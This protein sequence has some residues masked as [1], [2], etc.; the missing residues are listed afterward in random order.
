MAKAWTDALQKKLIQKLGA[1]KGAL[2]GK[3]YADAFSHSYKEDFSPTDALFDIELIE[4]LSPNNLLEIDIYEQNK[5]NQNRIYLKLLQFGK[6]IPLSDVLPM[7]ENMDLRTFSERPYRITVD[8]DTVIWLS[9]FTLDYVEPLAIKIGKIEKYFRDA[10]IKINNGECENDG[11]NKLILGAELPWR[12]VMILRIYAKYLHQIGFRLGQSYIEK[13]L[14]KYPDITKL[15]VSLFKIKFD[16]EQTSIKA[17][18]ATNA[19]ITESIDSVSSLDED[20]ILRNIWKL[21][22]ATLRTNYFQLTKKGV[23]KE[24]ISLKLASSD[25]PDLPLPHPLYE[26]FVYSPRFEAIHLRSAKVARGGIRWSDRP[27]DFRTEVLGLMK[28]QKVKNAIIVPSGAKGGF[29]LK[30][31]FPETTP[32]ETLQLEV[33]R[34]YK[35]FMRG[36]LDITDN[37]KNEKVVHP[38]NVVCYDDDDPYLVVAADK[39]TST[40][41]DIANDISKEYDFWL[42]DAF[43]SGGSTGYDH[44]KM[45]ITARGAWESIKRHFYGLNI[46]I[47]EHEFTAIGIGDMSGDVFGNGMIYTD[48]IKLVAAFDYRHIFIDP[49]PSAK[50]AFNE[51]NRLFHLPRS[52]WEDYNSKLIS[53]GGGVFS[54]ALKSIVITPEM[55][56]ALG[57]EEDALSPSELVRAILKAPVDLFYNGGIGTYVKASTESHADVGDKSN[58]YTRING[59]ELRCKIVGEG[60]NLG[61]TQL[62]RVEYAL[63]GGLI[64][65]DF[66]DNSAG[67]DCSDHEVNIK[68]LLNKEMQKKK[69]SEKKRNALLAAMTQE[70]SD[71]V[72]YDNFNQALTMAFSSEHS[73]KLFGLYHSYLQELETQGIVNRVVEFLPDTKTLLE[74][75]A[76]GKSLVSPELAIL[77]AYTKIHLKQEILKTNVPEDPFLMPVIEK[78][79]PPILYKTYKKALLDHP[80][81]REIV[82]TQLSNHIVNNMGITF[83][84]RLQIE[85]GAHLGDIIRAH[86]VSER[87]FNVDELNKLI[88]SLEYKITAVLQYELL[89]HT[90]RLTNL[91]TRWF[92]Q[93]RRLKGDLNK[94]IKHYSENIKKLEYVVPT[95]MKGVT[96]SYLDFLTERFTES[97]ISKEMGRRIAITRAIYTSLNI[98]EVATLHRFDLIK[99]AKVYFDVGGRFGLVWFRDQIA[100]DNSEGHWNTLARLTLRDELDILQKNL[101]YAIIKNNK[102]ETNSHRLIEQWVNKNKYAIDRWEKVLEMI[103]ASATTDY[104]M[105]FIAIR[106]LSNWVNDNEIAGV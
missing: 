25:V 17:I 31:I 13:T 81:R 65:T 34:C 70:V 102:K 98:T 63:N 59:N 80:L 15:L 54:R 76:N 39:G 33:I 1:R 41:S 11:F 16:P 83:V 6:P 91:A 71:L 66:I 90:R 5:I 47:H 48:K 37:L 75:K 85:T 4:K 35:S 56:I 61:F 9:D 22:T 53:K 10:L 32:R 78:A 94:I 86:A 30:T 36:L 99:T 88:N 52:S 51:R 49:T 72:L 42:G 82:A 27:E 74:R 58:E 3:K 103:F 55:K 101:T 18:T 96:K 84:Y 23:C 12:E 44:K 97:G 14:I 64:N 57:I 43:A 106:E 24:Y 95:L 62:G 93:G 40:F 21:I 89:H 38:R 87:I 79:F 46:N 100:N 92:L 29:V 77:L 73:V 20:R 19:K 104:S 105:F 67:V 7:L 45:G 68:I 69:L 26:V 2:L 28:A 60:G 8:K 50:E